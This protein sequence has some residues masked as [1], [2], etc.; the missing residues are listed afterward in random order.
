MI[1]GGIWGWFW[2]IEVVKQLKFS[3]VIVG[4]FIVY[5]ASYGW[6]RATHIEIWE[7]DNRSYLIFPRDKMVVYYLYRPVTYVDGRLTGLGFHIGPHQE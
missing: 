3:L 4:F 1:R 6:F 7:K 2:R 5:L